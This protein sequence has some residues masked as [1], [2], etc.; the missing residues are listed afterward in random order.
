MELLLGYNPVIHHHEFTVRD[1]QA[2]QDL[3]KR[4]QIWDDQDVGLDSQLE[5]HLVGR[6]ESIESTRQ[7]YLTRFVSQQTKKGRL[8]APKEGELVLLHRA[9]LDNRYDKKLEAR[10]EGPFC[11]GNIAHHSQSERLFDLIT[12]RLVRTKQAGLK[13][14]IH[15]DNL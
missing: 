11:L 4:Q 12:G 1:R 5:S 9:A 7:R 3:Q 14:R 8:P 2:V 6:D 10:W 13:D 15:L